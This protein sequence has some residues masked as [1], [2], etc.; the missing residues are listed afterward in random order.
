MKEVGTIRE[1]V[2]SLTKRKRFLKEAEIVLGFSTPNYLIHVS[3]IVKFTQLRSILSYHDIS[4][5]T[6]SWAAATPR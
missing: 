1:A 6:V 5:I 2:V 3:Y 4:I